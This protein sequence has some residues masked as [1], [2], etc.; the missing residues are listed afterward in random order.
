M[1]E[2]KTINFN[3][4]TVKEHN[5]YPNCFFKNH[6]SNNHS[7]NIS[8]RT[9]IRSLW[10]IFYCLSTNISQYISKWAFLYARCVMLLLFMILLFI[11]L[12]SFFV[13]KYNG[14]K[15]Y[16]TTSNVFYSLRREKKDGYRHISVA[17][18]IHYVIK[19]LWSV[20]LL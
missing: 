11:F 19:K 1:R 6:A 4:H 5:T 8:S 14:E 18:A 13:Y 7:R 17:V 16:R 20:K 10:S 2:N 15:L 12:K 9:S 3:V